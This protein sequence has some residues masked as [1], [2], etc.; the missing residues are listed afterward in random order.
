[1]REESQVDEAEEWA[2]SNTANTLSGWTDGVCEATSAKMSK[3]PTQ[4]PASLPPPWHCPDTVAFPGTPV[5]LHW[6]KPIVTVLFL[7]RIGLDEGMWHHP[8]Q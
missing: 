3:L 6:A 7:A 2:L 5:K 8:G 4:Q 1:M